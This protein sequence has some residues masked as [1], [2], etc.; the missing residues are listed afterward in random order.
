MVLAA[1]QLITEA[2]TSKVADQSNL[3]D[4]AIEQM[5]IEQWVFYANSIRYAS[6]MSGPDYASFKNGWWKATHN[7]QAM[8]DHIELLKRK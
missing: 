8:S 5:W 2:W 7:L 3:F 4:E 6:A 1:T